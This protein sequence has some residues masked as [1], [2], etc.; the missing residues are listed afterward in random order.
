[1]SCVLQTCMSAASLTATKCEQQIVKL[2]RGPLSNYQADKKRKKR[3]G[4]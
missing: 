2:A 1:M 4:N 3:K